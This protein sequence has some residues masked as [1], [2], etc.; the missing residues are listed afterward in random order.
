MCQLWWEMFIPYNAFN[1]L[2][3]LNEKGTE[4]TA[5]SAIMITTKMLMVQMK[6]QTQPIVFKADHPFIY[7]I[8]HNPTKL[9]TFIGRVESF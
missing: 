7:A 1:G 8:R 6:P 3:D 9:I 2:S 5:A 4:A